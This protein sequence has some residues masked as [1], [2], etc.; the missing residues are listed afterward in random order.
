M[1]GA[2][3]GDLEAGLKLRVISTP[4]G[5]GNKFYELMTG[6]DDG[7]SCHQT[8]IHQA[9][10]QGLPRNIGGVAPGRGR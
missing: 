1:E 9:V 5:K 6:K 10:A 4:N 8:N 7:W 3:P 2:V